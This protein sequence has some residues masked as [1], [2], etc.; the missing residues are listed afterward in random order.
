[1]NLSLARDA[2]VLLVGA[3]GSGKST[4]AAR[5]FAP[6]EILAS[7]DLRAAASGDPGDQ[8]A[9]AVA[10]ALLH[11]ALERRMG[12]GVLTVIDATNVQA[13]A[14]ARLLAAA[15]RHHRPGTAIVF[16]VPLDTCLDRNRRRA[17]RRVPE[18]VVRRQH[19][20]MRSSLSMLAKEG[21]TAVWVLD[22]A[23]AVDAARPTR[24][25]T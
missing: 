25:A 10:F 16:D 15:R 4:F 14:R 24:S 12:D 17:G 6:D 23:E 19:A 8:S 18:A 5:H 3:S 20:R 13:W 21:F 9:T 11:R 1:V 2:L 22:S 7:D